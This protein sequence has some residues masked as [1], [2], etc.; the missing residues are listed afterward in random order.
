M[1]CPKYYKV[2][3]HSF[4]LIC[5][6][7]KH[8]KLDGYDGFLGVEK[9]TFG[10]STLLCKRNAKEILLNSF[11]VLANFR[12]NFFELSRHVSLPSM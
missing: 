4:S 1:F 7:V 8:H 5:G 9:M 3:L 11:F 12:R 10:L 2:Q 6:Q